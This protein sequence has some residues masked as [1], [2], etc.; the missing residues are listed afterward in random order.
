MLKK[1]YGVE[2][3]GSNMTYKVG[4][5]RIPD[6]WYRVPVDYM[7]PSFNVDLV[8]LL[9]RHPERLRYE[10][11]R[12]RNISA[13]E[14]IVLTATKN[15]IGGNTGSVNSFVGVDFSD[16][17]GGVLD[18]TNL[19]ENNNLLCFSFEVVRT[20]APGMLSNV[21]STVAGP[22]EMLMDALRSTILDTS[23]PAFQDMTMGG[24]PLN[25]GLQDRFPGAKKSGHA[26]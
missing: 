13:N 9:T 23:C 12:A 3:D 21:Y 10:D 8:Q 24:K 25:E 11:T 14:A 26:L 15:S 19:L 20:F 6:N 18:S 5:E 4:H 2:G 17:T 22:L 7:I 1:F 16:I